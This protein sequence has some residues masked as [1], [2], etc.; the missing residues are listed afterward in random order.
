MF[1]LMMASMM[2]AASDPLPTPAASLAGQPTRFCRELGSAPSRSQAIV[3]CRTKA[4]WARTESCTGA[5]RYCA[6][7]K[8]VASLSG[9][10][11]N[12]T[13]FPLNED[14]RILCKVMKHT[15]SRLRSTNVCLPKREWDR[16][17]TDTS[18]EMNHLQDNYSKLT[19][20]EQ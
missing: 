1:A 18:D 20:G 6:P 19:P 8:R 12:M 15:G 17:H 13:A 10:P 16:L 9:M 2:V 11:G 4:Q 14:S 5:T 7:R 3:I